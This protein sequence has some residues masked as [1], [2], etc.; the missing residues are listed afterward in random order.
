LLYS[1]SL[2]IYVA[3]IINNFRWLLLYSFIIWGYLLFTLQP[4]RTSHI[5]RFL[6]GPTTNCNKLMGTTYKWL[7]LISWRVNTLKLWKGKLEFPIILSLVLFF[8][9]LISAPWITSTSKCKFVFE[10]YVY[11]YVAYTLEIEGVTYVRHVSI[12]DTSVTPGWYI[13]FNHSH[14]F[15]L[16]SVLC[17]SVMNICMYQTFDVSCN[18]L[19][20]WCR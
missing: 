4:T 11:S 3:N 2:I 17:I 1:L 16:L 7:V 10:L 19:I 12:F 15:K 13:Q 18:V 20:I 8:F 6:C 9:Q 5:N 14:Y